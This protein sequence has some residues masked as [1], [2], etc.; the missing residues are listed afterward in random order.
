MTL[1]IA[2]A[3]V[4][5]TIQVKTGQDHAFKVFTRSGWWPKS[6][7]ILASKSPQK[8]V[9]MEPRAGG[10]W[11]E[12]GEDG[13]ECDWGKVIAWE[14][15]VRLLLAWSLISQ[16]Q[17]DPNLV[18]EVEVKFIRE[19]AGATRVELEHRYFERAGDGAEGLRAAVDAPDGWTGL[20]ERFA[21]AAAQ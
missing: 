1:T 13:S 7:S 18:T 20:M 19:S 9:I 16:F 17:Y 6:H 2:F 3:P 21:K 14:P 10:R 12:R 11:F 4:R 8:E 15:P 5:K